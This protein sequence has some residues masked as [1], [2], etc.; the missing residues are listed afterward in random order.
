MRFS[1]S[2]WC[3]CTASPSS[4]RL[5][6]LRSVG[7]RS[8]AIS[9]SDT[10]HG[11]TRPSR[12]V[13]RHVSAFGRRAFHPGSPAAD[14]VFSVV[15][16]TCPGS[17]TA[18]TWNLSSPAGIQRMTC[19]A[20]FRPGRDLRKRELSY[21]R[22]AGNRR[23]IGVFRGNRPE[24]ADRRMPEKTRL[25]GGGAASRRATPTGTTQAEG[26]KHASAERAESL[27]CRRNGHQRQPGTVIPPPE[28]KAPAR[29]VCGQRAI[30]FI[31][32]RRVDKILATGGSASK[33][34]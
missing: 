20:R 30:R 18:K 29:V 22:E 19:G 26:S 17:V 6:L 1:P 33:A 21:G 7:S 15:G 32:G 14:L 31:G 23:G 9:T 25:A 24:R 10:N 27:G 3:R 13:L 2:P 34:C 28:L 8:S 16:P 11:R 4:A 12:Q 5:S